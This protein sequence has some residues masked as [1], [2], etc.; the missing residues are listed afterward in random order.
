[1]TR[2]RTPLVALLVT[3]L[4]TTA[5][6]AFAQATLTETFDSAVVGLTFDHPTGW[7]PLEM[8]NFVGDFDIIVM[9][10]SQN[11][12]DFVSP[13]FPMK[14]GMVT[15]NLYPPSFVEAVYAP[16]P[17]QAIAAFLTDFP[18]PAPSAYPVQI[19]ATQA[20][21]F[22][23]QDDHSS[24]LVI[25]FEMPSGGTAMAIV[26]TAPGE[27]AAVE[28]TALA[29]LATVDRFAGTSTVDGSEP[30]L[31]DDDLSG[32]LDG[33]A[34]GNADTTDE[35]SATVGGFELAG[36][37][38]VAYNGMTFSHPNGWYAYAGADLDPPGSVILTDSEDTAFIATGQPLYPGEV[39]MSLY[40]PDWV[41][42]EFVMFNGTLDVVWV[43]VL[44]EFYGGFP[45]QETETTTIQGRPARYL[46]AELDNYDF[47]SV[48]MQV[49]ENEYV[50]VA[51]SV[52]SGELD[53]EA[54]RAFAIMETVVLDEAG[55]SAG[56]SL[57]K[58]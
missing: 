44:D 36:T 31:P 33:L 8:E 10:D 22:D 6:T 53:N 11:T 55:I 50:L 54:D 37:Y 40:P 9:G 46:E 15:M 45:V 43:N 25:A 38:T 3:A 12:L 23:Y 13:D 4:L 51:V 27:M 32:L 14:P 7:V 28:P 39:F 17:K 49:D 20:T 29:I 48:L 41:Q 56:G 34:G 21:A 30:A 24:G 58:K 5:V 57:E 52:A 18:D 19:G 47:M 1:M 26:D 35:E 42:Q 16:N 2:P